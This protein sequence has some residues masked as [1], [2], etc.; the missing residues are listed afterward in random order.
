MPLKLSTK[1]QRDLGMSETW[2]I[3]VGN[4]VYG[5]YNAEQMRAFHADTRVRRTWARTPEGA[6]KAS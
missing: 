2:T 6:R 5:P 3:S 4:R 1:I